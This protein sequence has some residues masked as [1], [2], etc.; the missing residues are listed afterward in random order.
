MTEGEVEVVLGWE[1][2][3]MA[4]AGHAEEAFAGVSVEDD[5]REAGRGG[6]RLGQR[7]R[8]VAFVVVCGSGPSLW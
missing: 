2:V 7:S 1:V 5:H 8:S 3:V 4:M 6:W